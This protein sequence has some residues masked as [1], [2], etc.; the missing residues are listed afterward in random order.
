[1]FGFV[2]IAFSSLLSGLST[3]WSFSSRIHLQCGLAIIYDWRLDYAGVSPWLLFSPL[4]M[5]RSWHS[6]FLLVSNSSL[7]GTGWWFRIDRRLDYAGVSPWIPFSLTS[8]CH[9]LFNVNVGF[10]SLAYPF[11]EGSCDG[12]WLS[13]GLCQ[14]GSKNQVIPVNSV[15]FCQFWSICIN[16]EW[17][18]MNSVEFCWI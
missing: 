9:L 6:W 15:Q 8:G 1:M 16:L 13:I 10:V 17:I 11:R 4:S 5:V 12:F 3:H 18:L 2:L 14:G 7:V